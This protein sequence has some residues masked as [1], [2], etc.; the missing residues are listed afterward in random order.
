MKTLNLIIKQTY[1]DQILAGTKT[2]E[3]REIKPTTSKKLVHYLHGGIV[4]ETVDEIPPEGDIEVVPIKYDAIQFYVGYNT[5]RDS[6]LVEVKNAI[7]EF[8]IDEN[9]EEIEYE[10][11]GEMYVAAQ[12]VYD[13]GKVIEKNIH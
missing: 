9:G 2:Q 10:Y 11:K 7:V 12:I 3:F 4:Y 1:F 13:L 5:D 8:F 6:A